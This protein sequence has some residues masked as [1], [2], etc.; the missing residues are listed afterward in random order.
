M[1]VVGGM[2][3]CGGCLV[4][5][6]VLKFRWLVGSGLFYSSFGFRFGDDEKEREREGE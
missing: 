6:V 1:V 2:G 4:M 3:D 5:V